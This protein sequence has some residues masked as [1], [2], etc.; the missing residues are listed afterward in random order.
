MADVKRRS[1]FTGTCDCI[2]SQIQ[3]NRIVYC[4]IYIN[5]TFPH[6]CG[7]IFNIE[8]QTVWTHDPFQKE[9]I[10]RRVEDIFESRFQPIMATV[11]EVKNFSGWLQDDGYSCGV[12]VVL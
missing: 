9:D 12:L 7:I 3:T 6:W 2:F 1:G 4:P 8:R 10:V 5:V 11:M